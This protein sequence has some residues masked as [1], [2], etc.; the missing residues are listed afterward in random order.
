MLL[1]CIVKRKLVITMFKYNLPVYAVCVFIPFTAVSQTQAL[2]ACIAQKSIHA[3]DST[4]IGELKNECKKTLTNSLEK[5]R[6]LESQAAP[7]P[8]SILPHKPNYVMPA[9]YSNVSS[10]PYQEQL[11]GETL[12]DIETKFQVSLK[13][14]A[15]ENAYFDDLDIYAA[16]TAVSWWQSYNSDISAP[17]RETNYEPE[18]I[19]NYSQPWQLLGVDI[20]NTSLSLNHQSN[21]QAGNLSR[22]WNRVIGAVT[23]VDDNLIWNLKAWWRLPEEDKKSSFLSDGDDNPNIENYLGY[24]ELGML[25]Q[26]NEGHNLDLMFRNNLKSNN[27]STFQLGWSFPLTYRLRGYVEYFNG[28]GDGLIYY[29]QHSSRLSVGV[30]LTDW[31]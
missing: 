23:I 25:W 11:E 28:Y 9:S 18:L 12:D 19:F 20:S 26:I 1:E 3:D 27:R 22:S 14:L 5:R 29:N 8:F 6:A 7:N 13:Y 15:V 17:F 16:F 21:G 30:K 31:L 2:S 4:T 10:K 24:G